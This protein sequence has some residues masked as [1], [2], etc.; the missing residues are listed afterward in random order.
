[1]VQFDGV[2]DAMTN[3]VPAAS[4]ATIFI[5]FRL[6]STANATF[7]CDGISANRCA[8][9]R[10]VTDASFAFS[11]GTSVNTFGHNTR[12]NAAM[13]SL[14]G[15]SSTWMTNA[16]TETTFT[17]SPG[18]LSLSGLTLAARY[19]FAAN[20]WGQ[21]DIAEI[22]ICATANIPSATKSRVM[23]YLRIKWGI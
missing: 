14:N 4:Q 9:Y 23:D 15:A 19:N 20:Y 6:N 3:T 10:N 22:I 21:V 8:F 11:D 1:M 12:W 18:T 13:L 7:I 5:A 2:N 17:N 16:T